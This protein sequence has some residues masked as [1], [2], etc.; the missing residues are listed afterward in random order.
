MFSTS[1]GIVFL[2]VLP[3]SQNQGQEVTPKE[4]LIRLIEKVKSDDDSVADAAR[5]D[6]AALSKKGKGGAFPLFFKTLINTSGQNPHGRIYFCFTG[7]GPVSRPLFAG[8][9]AHEQTGTRAD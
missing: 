1:L 7:K 3:L 9:S 5:H 2:C 6:V 8:T 4:T